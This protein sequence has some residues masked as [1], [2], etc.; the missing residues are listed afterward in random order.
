MGIWEGDANDKEISRFSVEKG[1]RG[2]TLRQLISK[3]LELWNGMVKDVVKE[4]LKEEKDR[5]NIT[6][7]L[8]PKIS[9]GE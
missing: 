7:R 1:W 4:V 5:E 6:S 2:L 3:G 9:L 8:R